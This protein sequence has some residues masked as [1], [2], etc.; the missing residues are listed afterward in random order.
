[1][2]KN[3]IVDDLYR[4]NVVKNILNKYY[5]NKQN[6]LDLEQDIYILIL[7]IPVDLLQELYS[8]GKLVHWISATVKNQI[9]SVTSNYYT[10]Y[11]K[12]GNISKEITN[13]TKITNE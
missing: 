13:E 9:K 5:E 1:M 7:Q 8:N 10:K 6:L 3:E 2:T 4:K 12:F 11:K